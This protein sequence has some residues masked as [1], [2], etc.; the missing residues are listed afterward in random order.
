VER[1]EEAAFEEPAEVVEETVAPFSVSTLCNG[2]VRIQPEFY[3]AVPEPTRPQTV[4]TAMH[5]GDLD[6][7]RPGVHDQRP[8]TVPSAPRV[9]LW[10]EFSGTKRPLPHGVHV[11]QLRMSA[12]SRGRS[13]VF[14]AEAPR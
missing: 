6:A 2:R 14:S 4:P 5:G 11:G 3:G 7:V 12:V 10:S 8:S 1:A 9:S 13:S